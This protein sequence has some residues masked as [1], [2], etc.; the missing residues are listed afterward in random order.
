MAVITPVPVEEALTKP[1]A[2]EPS[3]R[4]L[5]TRQIE[6]DAA[7]VVAA[8]NSGQAALISISHDDLPA[9]RYLT[10]LRSALR[11]LGHT[12]VLVQKRRGR[13]ELAAWKERPED[14]ARLATRRKTGQRLGLLAKQRA[15]NSRGRPRRRVG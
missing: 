8:V 3:A 1:I 2:K 6:K 11:R 10:G 9:A 7:E 13:D 12:E 5:R 15:K 14:Q 4:T